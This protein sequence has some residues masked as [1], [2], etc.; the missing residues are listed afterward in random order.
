MKKTNAPTRSMELNLVSQYNPIKKAA[1]KYAL[2]KAITSAEIIS[3]GAGIPK[4][5]TTTVSIVSI[6]NPIPTDQ[7]V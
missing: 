7:V 3:K 4:L 1:T 5:E 6:T 2:P